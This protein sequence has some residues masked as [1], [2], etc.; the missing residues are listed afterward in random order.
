MAA[1][2]LT[3]DVTTFRQQF[4]AFSNDTTFPDAMLQ[5]YWDM[6]ISYISDVGNYGWLQNTNRQLALNFLTAHLVA[7]SV[8]IA[9]GQVTGLMQTATIDKISVGLTPPPLPNQWQWWLNQTPYG[10]QLLALLAVNI[11]GGLYVGGL[12]ELSAFRKVGGTFANSGY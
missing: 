5:M 6:A 1:V 12:P 3:F 8:I 10:Q 11:T 2:I 4:P 7:L 9:A